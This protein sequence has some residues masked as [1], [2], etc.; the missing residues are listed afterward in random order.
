MSSTASTASAWRAAAASPAGPRPVPRSS[1]WSAG[2]T[3]PTPSGRS[4]PWTPAATSPPAV[5][6][7]RGR[8]WAHPPRAGWRL[9][10]G[11]RPQGSGCWGGCRTQPARGTLTMGLPVFSECNA[12]LCREQPPLCPLGFQVK[13]QMVPGRCCPRYSCGR[14]AG[15]GRREVRG[16]RWAWAGGEVGRWG[17]PGGS[18]STRSTGLSSLLFLPRA[19]GRVCHRPGRVPGEPRPGGAGAGRGRGAAGRPGAGRGLC[20]GGPASP[21]FPVVPARLSSLLV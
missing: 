13:S 6:R 3:A 9:G 18:A 2:R 10:P 14:W 4:T 7:P 20:V 17:G 15:R 19:Q 12:S 11:W 1:A 16:G 8:E 21:S 5:R